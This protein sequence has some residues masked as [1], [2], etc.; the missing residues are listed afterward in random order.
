MDPLTILHLQPSITVEGVRTID[1]PW[2]LYD[3]WEDPYQMQ[4][5]I[6]D[7]R[8][9][10]TRERLDGRMRA[11]MESVGDNLRPRNFYYQLFGIEF[12]NRGKVVD[13]V[14]NI[15]DRSG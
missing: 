5:L 15:Y 9:A 10:E 13:L 6:H 1:Q 14:E 12:D 4:N 2:F 3:N 8:H 7:Q 11:H